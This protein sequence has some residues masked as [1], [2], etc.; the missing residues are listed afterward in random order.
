MSYQITSRCQ[1]ITPSFDNILYVIVEILMYS[2][3]L[4]DIIVSN[5]NMVSINNTLY[6]NN[7]MLFYK[8]LSDD[9]MILYDV[10]NYHLKTCYQLIR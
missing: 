6:A 8:M 9:N 2:N 3:M 10:I 1:L 5:D 7:I 4:P